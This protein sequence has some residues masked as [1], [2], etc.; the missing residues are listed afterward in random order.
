MG[1]NEIKKLFLN[2]LTSNNLKQQQAKKVSAEANSAVTNISF[3]SKLVSS[4]I[5]CG[6]ILGYKCSEFTVVLQTT[7]S[8]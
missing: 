2:I 8:Q 7:T 6:C 4:L 1:Q 5:R 3:G